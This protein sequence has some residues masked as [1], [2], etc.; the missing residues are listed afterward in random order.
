[1]RGMRGGMALPPSVAE[2]DWQAP[3]LPH[4]PSHRQLL[5]GGPAIPNGYELLAKIMNSRRNAPHVLSSGTKLS[6]P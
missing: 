5:C 4:G 1:M 6:E 3:R 2:A